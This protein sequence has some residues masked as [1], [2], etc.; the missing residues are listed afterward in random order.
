MCVNTA[1]TRMSSRVRFMEAYGIN[2]RRHTLVHRIHSHLDEEIMVVTGGEFEATMLPDESVTLDPSDTVNVRTHV[3]VRARLQAGDVYYGARR[4]PHS[5]L[6]VGASAT[7][8]YVTLRFNGRANPR[9]DAA[10]AAIV[11]P[12]A[13]KHTIVD[14]IR[15]KKVSDPQV[16]WDYLVRAAGPAA[17]TC[18]T[19]A[20]VEK[21]PT[22]SLF[23]GGRCGGDR[24]PSETLKGRAGWKVD[25]P[26]DGG[27]LRVPLDA[28][29]GDPAITAAADW[30]VLTLNADAPLDMKVEGAQATEIKDKSVERDSVVYVPQGATLFLTNTA[31][32]N[33]HLYVFVFE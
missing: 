19:F 22:L 2:Q 5:M 21:S 26:S 15:E 24:V 7:S 9:D 28:P 4:S 14:A 29:L 13:D 23:S 25:V 32:T 3:P 11:D 16:L 20:S 17:R 1:F 12:I 10:I 18:V 8:T 31:S 30:I 27:V 6:A 33:A